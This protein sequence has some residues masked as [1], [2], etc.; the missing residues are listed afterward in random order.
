MITH[1]TPCI[2]PIA[3]ELDHIER[4]WSLVDEIPDEV[5]MICILEIDHTTER[6]EFII[7]TMHITDEERSRSHRLLFR[8][9]RHEDTCFLF[10]RFPVRPACISRLLEWHTR[11]EQEEDRDNKK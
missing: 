7:A 9:P 10:V 3:D 6:H 2:G 4:S 1:N 8:E 11:Y 5:E